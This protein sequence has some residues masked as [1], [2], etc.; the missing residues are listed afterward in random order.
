[1]LHIYVS[2]LLGGG[3]NSNVPLWIHRDITLPNDSKLIYKYLTRNTTGIRYGERGARKITEIIRKFP[4]C[5]YV[6][7]HAVSP[8][9]QYDAAPSAR[10]AFR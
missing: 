10:P 8:L 2:T 6:Q 7:Y 5:K 4:I 9:S 1:M 3:T